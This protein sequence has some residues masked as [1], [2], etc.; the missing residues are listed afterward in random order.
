MLNRVVEYPSFPLYHCPD[1]VADAE[2]ALLRNDEREMADQARIDFARM[3]R[4]MRARP[5]EREQ[6]RRRAILHARKRNIGERV[7]GHRAARRI[8]RHELAVLPQIERAPCRVIQQ[9]QVIGGPAR[10]WLDVGFE[11]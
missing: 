2:T 6:S 5:Q 4:D 8:L 1:V 11:G 7:H 9:T 10:S 3:G